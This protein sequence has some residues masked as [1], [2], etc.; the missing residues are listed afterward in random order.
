MSKGPLTGLRPEQ[1]RCGSLSAAFGHQ[2]LVEHLLP[3]DVASAG[4]SRRGRPLHRELPPP[5]PLERPPSVPAS[6]AGFEPGPVAGPCLCEHLLEVRGEGHPTWRYRSIGP[7]L[8]HGR[9]SSAG[10][11]PPS[12]ASR[13]ATS[14]P[15][16]TTGLGRTGAWTFDRRIRLPL[17]K[18]WLARESDGETS[19]AGSFMNISE[20][21]MTRNRVSERDRAMVRRSVGATFSAGSSTSTTELRRDRVGF[22]RPTRTSAISTWPADHCGD[23]RPLRPISCGEGA[24]TGRLP[25]CVRDGRA[26]RHVECERRPE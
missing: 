13:E 3:H 26:I 25:R 20:R 15:S 7:P 17:R 16:T 22:W 4:R 8:K 5:A 12:C 23:R 10:V 6:Q 14:T 11:A 9:S 2:H 18:E 19:W 24:T 21:G 1:V